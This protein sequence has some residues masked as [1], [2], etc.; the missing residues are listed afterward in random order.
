MKHHR[1]LIRAI[2]ARDKEKLQLLIVEHRNILLEKSS[3]EEKSELKKYL[4]T[5]GAEKSE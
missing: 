4:M 3:D 1:A 5:N 2:K